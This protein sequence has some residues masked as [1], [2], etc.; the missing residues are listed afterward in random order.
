MT[1][2]ILWYADNTSFYA[3][4]TRKSPNTAGQSLQRVLDALRHY[5]TQ[6]AIWTICSDPSEM[7]QHSFLSDKAA[8]FSPTYTFGRQ[9]SPLAP[10]TPQ[11]NSFKTSP[12]SCSYQ[13]NNNEN[14]HMYLGQLCVIVKKM[15][16]RSTQS[17]ISNYR[18]LACGSST[19]MASIF[20]GRWRLPY[21]TWRN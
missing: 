17:S 7:V 14:E 3:P 1:T 15:L 21:D 13:H 19:I 6:W 12:I 4:L 10:Q 8:D 9:Q 20:G 2:D 16:A 5:G 18:M 11:F